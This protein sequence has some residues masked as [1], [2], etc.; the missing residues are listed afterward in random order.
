MRSG[1]RGRWR[2][3]GSCAVGALAGLHTEDGLSHALEE[4]ALRLLLRE[5]DVG[6][7]LH[8]EKA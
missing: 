7:V 3:G 6:L 5:L 1:L 8:R 2:L 4:R